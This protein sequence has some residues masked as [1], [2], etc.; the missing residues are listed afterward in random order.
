MPTLPALSSDLSSSGKNE[1]ERVRDLGYLTAT[2][3][4]ALCVVDRGSWLAICNDSYK[5]PMHVQ[6]AEDVGFLSAVT[7]ALIHVANTRGW[8]DLNQY[9][10]DQNEIV[11]K[12]EKT[13]KKELKIARNR[14]KEMK[15]D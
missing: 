12:S 8:P 10:F 13:P 15:D 6:Y 3:L 7:S 11:K 4:R 2:G 9:L 5:V 14:M 1:L